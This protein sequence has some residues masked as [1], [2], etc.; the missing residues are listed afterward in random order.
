[1]GVG[2]VA[3]ILAYTKTTS[4]VF[5]W[6]IRTIHRAT[7][8]TTPTSSVARIFPA[9]GTQTTNLASISKSRLSALPIPLAP[10]DRAVRIVLAIEDAFGKI[11][12]LERECQHAESLLDKFERTILNRGLEGRLIP[13]EPNDEPAT[14]LLRRLR[15]A[16]AQPTGA[17]G[18]RRSKA[19]P[20][21]TTA[22][23][24]R[25]KMADKTRADVSE[26][27][28]SE[29]LRTL[30]GSAAAQDLW[31]RSELDI[32]DFYKLLRDEV[33]ARR[34][35]ETEDKTRLEIGHAS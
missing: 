15:D 14:V 35:A 3:S 9:R 7:S 23:R 24:G 6:P 8:R 30:G 27:H 1:M 34:I 33:I 4:F 17:P 32:D 12:I 10:R 22:K 31:L 13:Q 18:R 11:R 28:L 25:S 16:G 19:H 21:T 20:K 5:A 2:G 29:L 26:H